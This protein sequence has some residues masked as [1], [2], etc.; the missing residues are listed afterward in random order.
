MYLVLSQIQ[1]QFRSIKHSFG[2][3]LMCVG[4]C[5]QTMSQKL[6]PRN[7]EFFVKDSDSK[8]DEKMAN[9]KKVKME[10]NS[11]E[12]ISRSHNS[13]NVINIEEI[14]S[15]IH[16]KPTRLCPSFLKF[17][18]N[19]TIENYPT[20]P[21]KDSNGTGRFILKKKFRIFPFLL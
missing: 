19:L 2:N 13:I 10:D 8:V 21:I 3:C 18:P 7:L 9:E 1:F 20:L 14:S 12:E 11:I 17:Y 6:K 5:F 4:E 15:E 16:V